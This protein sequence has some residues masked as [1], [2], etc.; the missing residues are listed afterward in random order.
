MSAPDGH[1]G[2]ACGRRY[3]VRGGASS[4]ESDD[5]RVV[6]AM[7]LEAE[8]RRRGGGSA[9]GLVIECRGEADPAL[10]RALHRF[11]P[12]VEVR[13]AVEDLPASATITPSEL[14]MLFGNPAPGPEPA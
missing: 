2:A 14:S 3:R 9:P 11:A 8:R 4:W 6:F 13:R 7:V 1:L 12:W 5:A 10:L